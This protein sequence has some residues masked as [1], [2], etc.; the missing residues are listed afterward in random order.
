MWRSERSPC[1][2]RVPL[3]VFGLTAIGGPVVG[4]RCPHRRLTGHPCFL[5]ES[6]WVSSPPAGRRWIPETL[7]ASSAGTEGTSRR[8]CENAPGVAVVVGGWS[9]T[10]PRAGWPCRGTRRTRRL[11]GTGLTVRPFAGRS[12]QRYPNLARVGGSGRSRPSVRGTGDMHRT[13]EWDAAAVASLGPRLVPQWKCIPPRSDAGGGSNT[14]IVRVSSTGVPPP[15]QL[16]PDL[17]AGCRNA[18]ERDSAMT[19]VVVATMPSVLREN[20]ILRRARD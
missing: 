17:K 9:R 1:S 15:R 8:R 13:P 4:L 3:R 19:V 10:G 6:V 20:N 12:R 2:R 18:V 14:G 16:T 11:A 7:P 5:T